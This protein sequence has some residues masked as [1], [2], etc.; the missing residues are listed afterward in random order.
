MTIRTATRLG[1][2]GAAL[3]LVATVGVGFAPAPTQLPTVTVHHN[4]T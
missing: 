1:L 3:A 4:P 2:G